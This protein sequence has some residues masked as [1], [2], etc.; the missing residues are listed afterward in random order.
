MKNVRKTTPLLKFHDQLRN[1][2]VF[3]FISSWKSW[4]FLKIYSAYKGK[5]IA[6]KTPTNVISLILCIF[7]TL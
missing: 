6:R 4:N 2:N 3:F 5:K 1:E 7:Y